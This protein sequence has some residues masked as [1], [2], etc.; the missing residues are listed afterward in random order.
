MEREH[1]LSVTL[2]LHENNMLD[3]NVSTAKRLPQRLE[4]VIMKVRYVQ[5]ILGRVVMDRDVV[6]GSL[7]IA[8]VQ[9]KGVPILEPGQRLIGR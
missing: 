9:R 3:L 7:L 8:L 1:V 6:P 5:R 4:D 2:Q